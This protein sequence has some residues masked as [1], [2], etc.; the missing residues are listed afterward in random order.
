MCSRECPRV[1]PPHNHHFSSK[2][3][4]REMF[5]RERSDSV[6][7]RETAG[8]ARVA[9]RSGGPCTNAGPPRVARPARTVRT[10][11]ASRPKVVKHA[12][13]SKARIAV[14]QPMNCVARAPGRGPKV[15]LV[16]RPTIA[17]RKAK[18]AP[19]ARPAVQAKHKGA[20]KPAT[21]AR[22]LPKVA[23]RK[24]PPVGPPPKACAKRPPAQVVRGYHANPG[25]GAGRS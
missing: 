1:A 3:I 21:S 2:H 7:P 12:G 9:V 19:G 10:G 15:T 4:R 11:A 20:G 22:Q 18:P 13:I 8:F 25:H 14:A 24:S 5:R 23:P 6:T 16:A 17:V